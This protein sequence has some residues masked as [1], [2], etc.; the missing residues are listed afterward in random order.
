MGH[1]AGI[2]YSGAHQ[3]HMERETDCKNS[4]SKVKYPVSPPH[5]LT[6]LL[7]GDSHALDMCQEHIV[8]EHVLS[9]P[10]Y[11]SASPPIHPLPLSR[12]TK[13]HSRPQTTSQPLTHAAPLHPLLSPTSP[14]P[15]GCRGARGGERTSNS[16]S[17]AGHVGWVSKATPL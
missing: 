13:F 1:V 17:S 15:P 9:L 7:A 10:S 4:S 12:L 16:W 11:L 3:W 5:S 2:H 6:M 14:L 8:C